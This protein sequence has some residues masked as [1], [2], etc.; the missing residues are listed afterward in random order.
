MKQSRAMARQAQELGELTGQ[1]TAMT[2][3]LDELIQAVA[4]LAVCIE[5]AQVGEED[6]NE[7]E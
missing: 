5:R 4:E 7:G 3:K 6:D 1:V 2:Q